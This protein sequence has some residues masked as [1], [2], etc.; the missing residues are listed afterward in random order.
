MLV[1][2]F[3]NKQ[4]W[5][6]I[7]DMPLC[8]RLSILLVDRS[9]IR[10]AIGK[11]SLSSSGCRIADCRTFIGAKVRPCCL[12]SYWIVIFS[13]EARSLEALIKKEVVKIKFMTASRLPAH[14]RI[15][16]NDGANLL[17]DYPWNCTEAL[18]S[19]CNILPGMFPNVSFNCKC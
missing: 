13:T 14:Y 16:S 17:A 7:E 1:Y 5:L 19:H 9:F 18:F 8:L 12:F 4:P 2:E 6:M 15:L 3:F 10:F 11:L